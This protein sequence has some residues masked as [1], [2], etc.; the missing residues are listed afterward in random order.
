MYVL[1]TRSHDHTSRTHSNNNNN[2][3]TPTPTHNPNTNSPMASL[4]F[5]GPRVD[6]SPARQVMMQLLRIGILA[7]FCL[8]IVAICGG[9]YVDGAIYVLC[10]LL[11]IYPLRDKTKAGTDLICL[12]MMH[13]F[14]AIFAIL[15]GIL[16]L[17]K[18]RIY[19][20]PSEVWRR[21]CLDASIYGLAL[22]FIIV[23]VLCYLIF[24]EVRRKIWG[25]GDG[26]DLNAVNQPGQQQTSHGRGGFGYNA[27]R[28]DDVESGAA[29]K[30]K[31]TSNDWKKGGG[32]KLG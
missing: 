12:L 28:N 4:C 16:H 10:S 27:D 14:Q 8:S 25:G 13:T 19:R 15:Y 18:V 30:K 22:T 24:R 21:R 1:P 11:Y 23:S 29:K 3:K 2:K 26:S 17:C 9:R 20:I 5:G 7:E 31:D 32:R 6:L